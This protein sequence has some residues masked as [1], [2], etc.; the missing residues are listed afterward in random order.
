MGEGKSHVRYSIVVPVYNGREGLE[1]CL[2]SL[3]AQAQPGFEV[4]VVDD[5]STEDLSPVLT[6]SWSFPLRNLRQENSGPA[7]ARNTGLGLT[8]GDYVVFLDADDEVAPAWLASIDRLVEKDAPDLVSTGCRYHHIRDG[9]SHVVHPGPMG[10]AFFGLTALFR[11]GTYAVRRSMVDEI[12]GFIPGLPFGEHFELAL[13]LSALLVGRGGKAVATPDPL[14]IKHHDRRGPKSQ[15]YD[16]ARVEGVQFKL[17]HHLPQLARDPRL[18]ADLRGVAGINLFRLGDVRAGRQELVRSAV[19][20]PYRLVR[21][22]RV[23]IAAIPGAGRRIWSRGRS[24][25]PGLRG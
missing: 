14:M 19:A 16:R 12:G 6:A 22:G 21:W 10:P 11:P 3:E 18:L 9:S 13:R 15:S 17:A 20:D 4:V 2:L 5:G 23:A 8:T 1:R 7:A 24:D 25:V